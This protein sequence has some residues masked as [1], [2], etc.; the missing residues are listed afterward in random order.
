MRRPL[1]LP[2]RIA[3]VG[4]VCLAVQASTMLLT[5]LIWSGLALQ[6]APASHPPGVKQ[7][8]GSTHAF[9]ELITSS[10]FSDSEGHRAA[11]GHEMLR[12]FRAGDATAIAPRMF[13]QVYLRK[14]P[15]M[16]M[17]IALATALLGPHEWAARSVSLISLAIGTMLSTWAAARWIGPRWALAAGLAH[18]LLPVLWSPARSAEI[19]SLHNLGVQVA[20][21]A[22]IELLRTRERRSLLGGAS[23]LLAGACAAGGLFAAAWTKGP[24]AIPVV[25]GV[26]LASVFVFRPGAK[27]WGTAAGALALGTGASLLALGWVWRVASRAA[28]EAG[29]AVVAQSPGEFLWDQSKLGAIA[30][31]PLVALAAALP[32]SLGITLPWGPDAQRE[33]SLGSSTLAEES[34]S[35]R[36]IRA[37][38]KLCALGVA[39]SLMIW[40]ASGI[41]NPRY[42]MPA[43]FLLPPLVAYAAWGLQSGEAGFVSH[44]RK[45][46]RVMFL[47]SPRIALI[48]LLVGS[49]LHGV[50]TER[51]LMESS[52]REDGVLLASSIDGDAIVF[53]DHAIEA[54]PEL[55]LSAE[56]TA[57]SNGR[58]LIG[59]WLPGLDL[60]AA[61]DE[62]RR[63]GMPAFV[64]IRID[65]GSD[66]PA[67]V[68][69]PV[70]WRGKA[71][72]YEFGLVPLDV[73]ADSGASEPR[74]S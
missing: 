62:A 22:L 59:R 70:I 26:L 14:P 60:D 8:T 7:N 74:P 17:A 6:S 24:Q 13:E 1:L 52:A 20:C 58:R 63:R 23:A 50:L 53:A 65:S 41:H 72:A 64:L 68:S 15:G 39:C 51:S 3:L 30:A 21:I 33:D 29:Q 27:Q 61:R 4:V 28:S 40:L 16:P 57:S 10:G 44:R 43:W 9:R 32:L 31:F 11:P 34:E 46:V 54:R 38:A 48:V 45:I 47:G 5:P 67:R 18:A 49:L 12:R 19:E 69:G 37:H 2:L 66:E 55:L 73:P 35:P 36:E 71:E 42:A 25:V 56:H